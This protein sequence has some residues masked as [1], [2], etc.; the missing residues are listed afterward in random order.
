MHALNISLVRDL[1]PFD[2]MEPNAI[3]DL[4]DQGTAQRCEKGTTIFREGEQAHSFFLLLDGHIQVVK[5]NAEGEQ[6]IARYISGGELYGI[7][8]AIGRDTYPA[9]AIAAVDCV[10]IIWPTRIWDQVI[11]THP[12][13]ATNSYA[14]VGKRL[15]ETQDQVMALAMNKVEQRVANALLRLANQTGKKTDEGIL[16]DFPITRQDISE[17][18][19]TTLHTVSRLMSK[20]EEMGWVSSGRKKVVLVEGHK[21]V[22]VGSGHD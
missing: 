19:G 22:M 14:T 5:I 21:L 20:W 11:T 6:M 9:N 17:M 1:P 10:S 13:F 2:G 15:A 12:A 8:K 3:Q 7:A 4:L 18:T 16:I